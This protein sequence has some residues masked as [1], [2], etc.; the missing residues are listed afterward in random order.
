MSSLVMRFA[1]SLL[2]TLLLEL[3]VA[4]A[5]RMKGKDLLLVVLVNVLTNPAA[6]LLSILS[7]NQKA[8]QLFIEAVVILT[9]GWYYKK[10]GSKIK[11]GYVFSFAANSISYGLGEVLPY[12][13]FRVKGMIF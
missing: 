8:V 11:R 6:V 2:L 1:I 3:I 7:G 10:F 12:F 9:E 13:V 4:C 5:F